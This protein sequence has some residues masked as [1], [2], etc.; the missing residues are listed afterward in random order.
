MRRQLPARPGHIFRWPPDM[1]P[2]TFESLGQ[3]LEFE[4]DRRMGTSVMVRRYGTGAKERLEPVISLELHGWCIALFKADRV[5]FPET[6]DVRIAVTYW[7]SQIVADSRIGGHVERVPR[8]KR[9]GPGLPTS[10]GKAGLLV[11]DGDR[12][13]PVEGFAYRAGY[14]GEE[15]WCNHDSPDQ[16]PGR[17]CECGQVAPRHSDYRD[18]RA[19]ELLTAVRR[20]QA[21][22]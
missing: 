20:Q 2:L 6:R 8:R 14:P 21:V 12:D 11:I 13:R 1:P 4:P 10:R 15:P 18:R 3:W 22:A 17:P 9:D 7:L 5:I 19:A 16:V